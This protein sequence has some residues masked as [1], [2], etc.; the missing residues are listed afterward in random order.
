MFERLHLALASNELGIAA[1]GRALQPRAQ[2]ANAGDLVHIDR[3]GDSLDLVPSP[4]RA[5][6]PLLRS[7]ESDD[8]GADESVDA[9]ASGQ[10]MVEYLMIIAVVDAV[11]WGTR[12]MGRDIG[13]LTNNIGSSMS[14]RPGVVSVQDEASASGGLHVDLTKKSDNDQ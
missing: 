8:H 6:T 1:T 10:T 11:A 4:R 12:N 2:R 7:P 5:K 13:A 3:L 9:F 14:G